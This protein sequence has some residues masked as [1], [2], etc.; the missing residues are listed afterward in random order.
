MSSKN[1]QTALS[2]LESFTLNPELIQ[3]NKIHFS[4]DNKVF[5]V[6]MPSQKELMEA[7][8]LKNTHQV[9]LLK[10]EDTLTTKQLKALLKEK[11]ID[12]DALQ[13]ELEKLGEE[14]YE[15]YM[16]LANTIDDDEKGIEKSKKIIE[17]IKQKKY[18]LIDEISNHLTPAIEIQAENYYMCVLTASCTERVLTKENGYEYEKVWKDLDEY[19]AD[20][21]KEFRMYA[22]G[23]LTKLI[24]HTR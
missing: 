6:R 18:E 7:E 1:F 2:E 22:M 23:A 3:D 21:N 10:E 11:G 20:R 14:L 8:R 12:T 19:M 13:K 9:R 15:E 4:F 17:E 5:R 16:V 24:L